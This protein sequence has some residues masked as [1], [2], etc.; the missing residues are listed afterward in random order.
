[1]FRS[2]SVG[3]VIV[4][5]TLAVVV[6]MA[7]CT[8]SDPAPNR[9][10]VTASLGS[11]GVSASVSPTPSP[12]PSATPSPSS[13]PIDQIPPGRPASWVPAGVPT[14]AK[15]REPGDV[16]PK[17]TLAMFSN[18]ANGA[19]ATA[20]YYI[21]ARNWSAATLSAKPF[22]AIC[23]AK[24]CQSDQSFY[25]ALV[26]SNQHISG[27]REIPATVQ[28]FRAPAISGARWIVRVALRIAAGNVVDPG[29]KTVREQSAFSERIDIYLKWSGTMWR[30]SDVFLAD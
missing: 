8:H 11:P 13:V 27:G 26:K 16:V 28:A 23:D 25:S 21:E 17:F 1:M 10:T 15:W 30:V 14:T 22:L 24:K 12:T 18:D 4:G 2:L 19:L 6:G 20:N 3:P 5:V 7:G 9:S 29:G